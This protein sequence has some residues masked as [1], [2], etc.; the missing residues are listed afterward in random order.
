MAGSDAEQAAA[1]SV[2]VLERK[3]ARRSLFTPLGVD[4]TACDPYE[5]V[6]HRTAV[7]H[8]GHEPGEPPTA[9]RAWA[10]PRSTGLAGSM[11]AMR[12][13]DLLAFARVHTPPA[14]GS[15]EPGSAH[16]RSW[17]AWGCCSASVTWVWQVSST[18]G[19][20]RRGRCSP[21][22]PA[23]G[24]LRAPPHPYGRPVPGHRRDGRGGRCRLLRQKSA[25]ER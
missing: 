7:G 8:V 15:P 14:A 5:A 1:H 11:L 24:A 2:P 18:C 4:H 13:R 3:Q 9:T 6:L 21:P 16:R 20:W 23:R 25:C 10:M 19:N 17:S 12:P 22:T